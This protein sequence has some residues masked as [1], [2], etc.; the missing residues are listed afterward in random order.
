MWRVKPD[1]T[2]FLRVR[3]TPSGHI[4]GGFLPRT[5][6]NVL[7]IEN[8]WARLQTA[9]NL[10][11]WVN[12]SYIEQDVITQP[13]T[14]R[15]IGVHLHTGNNIDA[16]LQL[17]ADCAQE[18]KPISIAVVINNTGLANAIKRVSKDTFVVFR[19]GIA[20]DALDVLDL[21]KDN[22]DA[23]MAAGRK[24]FEQRY[25]PCD[26]DAWQIAN[27]HYDKGHEPWKVKAM[28]EFYVGAMF[29]AEAKGVKITVFDGSTGT[30]EDEDLPLMAPMLQKAND[31]GHYLNYHSYAA[32]GVFDMTYAA[33][34][35]AMRF[36]RIIRGYPKL[37]VVIG[38]WGGY[39]TNGGN[40]MPMARQFQAMLAT[41]KIVKGAATFTGNAAPPW[42]SNGCNFD[43]YL[44]EFGTWHRSL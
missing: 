35:Y 41:N 28:A 40:I 39:G 11:A 3:C 43:P 16:C 27:E 29:A 24:R 14:Y 1:A 18:G 13:V 32:P 25:T 6:I 44:P 23:N 34:W 36:E 37:E 7:G 33:E 12:A 9:D 22:T 17:Y 10:T 5:P 30:P 26:A 31:D 8:G 21:T 2:P 38:E 4:L 15:K 42:D 20:G 19:G